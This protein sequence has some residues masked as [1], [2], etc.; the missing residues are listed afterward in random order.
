V[1]A[2]WI[3][4]VAPPGGTCAVLV[5]GVPAQ[6]DGTPQAVARL[7]VEAGVATLRA[8]DCAR[9]VLSGGAVANAYVEAD[10]M[11]GVARELGVP[12]DRIAL[13]REAANTWENVAFAEP[14]LA[15][16]DAVFVASDILH[17]RRA[18][19]YRCKQEPGSCA[20]TFAVSIAPPLRDFVWKVPG[21]LYELRAYVRDALVYGR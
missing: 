13:E 12:P 15:G 3:A 2:W 19:R 20:R 4:P 11:A 8:R 1:I 7:R 16:Y 6:G 17:A 18:V 5:P 21:A 10:V 14:L 9:L